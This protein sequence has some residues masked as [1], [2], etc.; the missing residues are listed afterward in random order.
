MSSGSFCAACRLRREPIYSTGGNSQGE[1]VRLNPQNQDKGNSPGRV[2]ERFPPGAAERVIGRGMGSSVRHPGQMGSSGTGRLVRGARP[3][4]RAREGAGLGRWAERRESG[5]RGG[6]PWLQAVGRPGPV[7][8]GPGGATPAGCRIGSS[9]PGAPELA[10]SE[11]RLSRPRAPRAER[12]S[13]VSCRGRSS[14]R[15][16]HC[17]LV[18]PLPSSTP[19]AGKPGR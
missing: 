13:P 7:C 8:P 16:H 10:R 11:R 1:R 5:R 2:P 9:R 4:V 12:S 17:H 15:S 14:A 6:R 18:I 19:R 3:Q